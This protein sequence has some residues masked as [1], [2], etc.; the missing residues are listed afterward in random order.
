MKGAVAGMTAVYLIASSRSVSDSISQSDGK[1]HINLLDRL[2]ERSQTRSMRVELLRRPRRPARFLLMI[3][4]LISACQKDRTYAQAPAHSEPRTTLVIFADK[5]MVDGEWVALFDALEKGA[6]GAEEEAPA[7]QGG[8]DLVRGDAMAR[9]LEIGKPISVYLHGDC[10]L[11]PMPR[12]TPVGVLGWVF[13]VHGRIEP[14]IHVDCAEIAQELG[15]LVLGMNSKRRD[16]VMGEAMA[17]VI[18]HEWVHVATQSAGHAAHGVAKSS[19]GI[20]DLL[21]EDEEVRRD[22]RIIRE[23][24][25]RM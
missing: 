15:P 7:L 20:G 22:P 24:L 4:L 18:L 21:A 12:Y 19:F 23:R 3:A 14:F 5:H 6:R 11:T 2:H 17:R 16:T 13:R 1:H 10:R 9:G 8:A 25:K